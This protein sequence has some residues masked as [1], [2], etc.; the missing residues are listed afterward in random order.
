MESAF[1]NEEYAVRYQKAR[2]LME[3]KKL[4][5]L[6]VTDAANLYYFTGYPAFA[7]MSF[8]RPAAFVLPVERDPVLIV[9]DFHLS[10]SWEGDIRE[11]SKVGEVPIELVRGVFEEVGCTQGR[12]GA[13]LGHEQHLAISYNDFTRVQHTLPGVEFVDAADVLWGLRMVKSEAEIAIISEACEIHDA[14]F[15]RCFETVRVGMT[16]REIDNLFRRVIIDTGADFGFTIVCVGDYDPRQAAGSSA[17]DCVLREGDLLWVDMGVVWHGYPTDYCRAVVGGKPSTKQLEAWGK[18]QQV[19]V[20][21]QEAVRP[22][23]P[24]SEL[25]RVQVKEAEILGLDM[26]TWTARRYGHGS[27]LHTT[28]PPYVSLDDDTILEPGMTIHIEPGLIRSDGIF[29]REEM[30][31]VTDSGCQVLSHA[32]WELRAV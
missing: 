19:L 11:Y 10:L 14:V 20:A 7:E 30:V 21:G 2:S 31:V 9:H 23:I 4:D 8:P 5:A 24:V 29:V 12:V 28:E 26:S 27:G 3:R 16:Q 6:F 25:C 17:P 15:K 13:E 22:G 18:V 1:S 32:P